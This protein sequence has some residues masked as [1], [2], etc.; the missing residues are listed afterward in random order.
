MTTTTTITLPYPT[1]TQRVVGVVVVVGLYFFD[2]ILFV[3]SGT[4]TEFPSPKH[5]SGFV[6]G[7]YSWTIFSLQSN[8]FWCPLHD[9]NDHCPLVQSKSIVQLQR[10]VVC[11][12]KNEKL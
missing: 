11:K 1:I 12:R 3:V 4:G 10:V 7:I 2:S 9:L 6:Q 8:F 5:G